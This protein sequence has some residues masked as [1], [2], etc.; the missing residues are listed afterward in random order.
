MADESSVGV[1]RRVPAVSWRTKLGVWIALALGV[2]GWAA[3][4]T[5]A[6]SVTVPGT[7]T[8]VA[9]RIDPIGQPLADLATGAFLGT[10][11][12]S[13]LYLDLGTT[14]GLVRSTL[15]GNIASVPA[16]APAYQLEISPAGQVYVNTNGLITRT[17]TA[18]T[19]EVV[20]GTGVIGYSGDGGAAWSAQIA[21]R[22]LAFDS[23][24]NVY[25]ASYQ[26]TGGGPL[27]FP[28]DG[29]IRKI[30][31]VTENISTVVGTGTPGNTGDAGPA[32]SATID[33]YGLDI[34]GLDRIVFL[35]RLGTDAFGLRRVNAD[36]NVVT[37]YTPAGGGRVDRFAAGPDGSV[38][39]T[40]ST[41]SGFGYVATN[42]VKRIA[43]GGA[44]STV[45]GT[46]TQGSTG[47]GGPATAA[48]L[49]LIWALDVL[50]DG[51]VLVGTIDDDL[52]GVVRAFTPGGNIDTVVG[53]GG[54]VMV[55]TVPSLAVAGNDRLVTSPF[56][57]PAAGGPLAT[58]D[59]NGTA[60]MARNAAG[61][62][63]LYTT[64]GTG[65]SFTVQ[66][67]AVSATGEVAPPTASTITPRHPAYAPDGTLYYFDDTAASGDDCRIRFRRS[68]NTTGVLA[69][70]D[71]SGTLVNRYGDLTV[72]PDGTLYN[73]RTDGVVKITAAGVVSRF[74]GKTSG[75]TAG[76][77]S[78]DGGAALQACFA[79]PNSITTDEVGNLYISTLQRVR[80]IDRDG[81]I[82]TIAGRSSDTFQ[83]A[84]DDGPA[85][86]ADLLFP[87]DLAFD[88]SGNLFIATTDA[89]RR[90]EGLGTK[91]PERTQ[92]PLVPGRIMDTRSPGGDTV[93]DIAQAIGQ[94]PADSTYELLVAGRGGVAADA[95]AAVLNVTVTNAAGDGFVTV[96]PCGVNR[97]NASNLNYQ[98]G[99]TVPNAVI[100]QIGTGGKVCFYTE[101]AIDL[102]VDVNGQYPAGTAFS[103]LVPARLLDSRSPGG[104]TF[105]DQFQAIGTRVADSTTELVV[106]GR[107]SVPADASAAVLNVTVTN[108][109]AEGFITVWPCGVARPNASNLNYVAGVTVPNAVITKIGTG[110]K[111][112]IYTEKAVDLIVDVNGQYPAGTA[113]SPLVPARLLDSRSPGGDTVDDI[114]QAIGTRTAGSTT[115]LVVATRGN[116]PA[117]ATAAV[118]NVTVTNV[119]GEGFVTV[120]PCGVNRPNAS[121]LN[122]VAGKT[123]P[124]A[125]I[126]KIGTDGKVCFYTEAAVDLIVDVNGF[127]G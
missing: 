112:C 65:V 63:E 38:Y 25:F 91:A 1:A 107:G 2:S 12:S 54:L 53:D 114:S 14:F 19:S 60:I 42:V 59:T 108:A 90:V 69:G 10:D 64:S 44:I 71:C 103:P 3:P 101:N 27:G 43:P 127:V 99:T 75:C 102:I 18:N 30:D 73:L 87:S 86:S 119:T 113:Y 124:N 6:G 89:I 92:A 9:E 58:I 77:D 109:A 70:G 45:A 82:T 79:Y 8:T 36:N 49:Q 61:D 29:R 95:T 23:A 47:D 39:F 67:S 117:Y 15:G 96:W 126:T 31:I 55:P 88:A 62:V 24:G 94:R 74:A 20:A 11:A 28:S 78:G 80:R 57:E 34:D 125:V 85:T 122:Y 5:P 116:V 100:T 83:N 81:I 98:A 93:D 123:V 35:Q 72:A 51:T 46:G 118:L 66:R 40:E 37:L 97:P 17:L 106:A 76:T 50:P 7:I 120:W 56:M 84:G 104:D 105:D 41:A 68:D 16:T 22:D 33:P 13:R 26:N 121:N 110:G 32:T 115:E 21:A 52:D 111:V 4:A 48:A